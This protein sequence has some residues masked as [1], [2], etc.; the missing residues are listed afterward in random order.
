MTTTTAAA[1][2]AAV[3]GRVVRAVRAVVIAMEEVALAAVAP[4]A[5]GNMMRL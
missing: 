5:L 3:A 2:T 1:V 4:E